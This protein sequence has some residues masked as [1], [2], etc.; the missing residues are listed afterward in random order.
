MRFLAVLAC[1]LVFAFIVIPARCYLKRREGRRGE[2]GEG[3]DVAAQVGSQRRPKDSLANC[4]VTTIS[5]DRG[6]K[7]RSGTPP[8][9]SLLLSG[10]QQ[11][12]QQHNPQVKALV[13]EVTALRQ[14]V[15]E[16]ELKANTNG[17]D[18]QRLDTD[19]DVVFAGV[20]PAFREINKL[21]DSVRLVSDLVAKQV[22]PVVNEARATVNQVLGFLE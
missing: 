2:E 21:S 7:L 8:R 12:Q 11:Q 18:I 19:I 1:L 3:E 10:P 16:V 6:S 17:T 20:N 13:E 14:E 22:V 4:F 5:C 15:Q 9:V